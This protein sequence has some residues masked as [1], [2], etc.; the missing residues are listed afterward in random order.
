MSAP[1]KHVMKLYPWQEVVDK[2][3]LLIK[4]GAY[5]YQ[6]WNCEHCGAKQTMG[7]P[8]NFYRTGQ[9]EECRKITNIEK[10]GH[11]FMIHIGRHLP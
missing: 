4:K 9:C 5:V 7:V 11:N 3:D 6:Q 8:N 10:N 1:R 2:A